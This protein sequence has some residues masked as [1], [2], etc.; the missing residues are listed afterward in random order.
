MIVLDTN[1]VS[2]AMKPE[3]QPAVRAWLNNQASE[4][5]YLSSVT[6]AEL[7][8]GIGALPPGKRKNMLGQTLD[9]LMKVFR[10]RVLPFDIDA[11][12]CYAKLAVSAR[13]GG[14]GFPTPDGYIAAIAHSRGFIVASRDTAPYEAAGVEVINPWLA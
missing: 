12:R 8:F 14:R 6:V 4:T 5:L 2:E 9:G 7:L 11:A 10:G 1:V 3:P 13:V